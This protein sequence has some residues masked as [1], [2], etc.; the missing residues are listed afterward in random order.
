MEWVRPGW[1]KVTHIQK[2]PIYGKRDT[3]RRFLGIPLGTKKEKYV[4]SCEDRTDERMTAIGGHRASITSLAFS[5]NGRLLAR[6]QLTAYIQIDLIRQPHRITG[7]RDEH[8]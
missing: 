8:Q 6:Q 2:L 1:M 7:H 3:P 4:E 5:S